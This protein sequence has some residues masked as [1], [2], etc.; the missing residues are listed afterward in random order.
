MYIYS[1][2]LFF[3][4]KVFFGYPITSY[5]ALTIDTYTSLVFKLAESNT[6]YICL[7]IANTSHLIFLIYLVL[8]YLSAEDREE[9]SEVG[10]TQEQWDKQNQSAK[11]KIDRKLDNYGHERFSGILDTSYNARV[12]VI[13]ATG[14]GKSA[15]ANTILGE[16]GHFVESSSASSV[17][18]GFST[19]KT[20]I[21]GREVTIY[22]TP[23]SWNVNII[24]FFFV[25][26][27]V[28]YVFKTDI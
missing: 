24:C 15:T 17:T 14:A 2:F 7:Y 18:T 20:S 19:A 26:I 25:I 6:H 11:L 1:I 12:V 23:G 22:D 27:G 4:S 3:S 10:A 16:R 28:F 8:Q 9:L 13:G 21:D 5:T